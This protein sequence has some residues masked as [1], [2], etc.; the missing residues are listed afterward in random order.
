MEWVKKQHTNL[1]IKD[2]PVYG[3]K[4]V[5]VINN[6]KI[7][8]GFLRKINRDEVTSRTMEIAACG[9]LL[10]AER[11]SRHNALFYEGK[12]AEF[13]STNKELYEKI[14]YYLEYDYLISDISKSG[15]RRCLQSGYDMTNQLSSILSKTM[16]SKY[17]HE[18]L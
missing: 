14:Q 2:K 17:S 16:N 4:Y 1:I 11:T 8:L 3:E 10:V 13:F 15:R 9:S 7:N 6:S 12:E 18:K 5:E